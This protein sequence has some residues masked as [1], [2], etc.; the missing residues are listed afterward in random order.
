MRL[1]ISQSKK[2]GM[3]KLERIGAL[4]FLP[5]STL[6]GEEEKKPFKREAKAVAALNHPNIYHIYAIDEADD[7]L[8]IA[9]E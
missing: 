1:V 9:M 8:F 6:T 4:K 5:T 7:Q 3:P 2:P